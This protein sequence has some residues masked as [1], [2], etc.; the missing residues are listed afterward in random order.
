MVYIHEAELLQPVVSH[1][2]NTWLLHHVQWDI[3]P[4][5]CYCICHALFIT[6]I[7]FQ[8]CGH[9]HTWNKIKLYVAET[10]Y[11]IYFVFGVWMAL[12]MMFDWTLVFWSD[13]W[14]YTP[15]RLIYKAKS[16]W[17]LSCIESWY[18]VSLIDCKGNK[19]KQKNWMRKT[20]T[21]PFNGPL[22][23]TTQVSRYEKAK[24]I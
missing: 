9:L 16:I 13:D 11:F 4:R 7:S 15:E 5:V 10:I 1:Q 6:L 14:H 22:S 17:Y 2:L 8:M 19:K 20:H 12:A 23:G 3:R 18:M 21:H 24:P